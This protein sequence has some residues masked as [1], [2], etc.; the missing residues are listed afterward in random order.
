MGCS[1]GMDSNPGGCSKDFSFYKKMVMVVNG[2]NHWRTME[3]KTLVS[4]L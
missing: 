1:R 4:K 3:V 2:E